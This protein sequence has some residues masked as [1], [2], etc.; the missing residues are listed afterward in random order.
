MWGRLGG[1]GTG[2]G[3]SWVP[4][5]FLGCPQSEAIPPEEFT[6]DTFR[7]FLSKLCLRP[8]IDKI[9]LEM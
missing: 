5:K 2:S 3:G 6:L 9:L 7:R 4:P 1:L 8:D